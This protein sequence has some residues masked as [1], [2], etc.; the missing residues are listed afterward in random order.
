MLK[1]TSSAFKLLYT[2]LIILN[3]MLIE[4]SNTCSHYALNAHTQ[5]AHSHTLLN[6]TLQLFA[7]LISLNLFRFAFNSANPYWASH[8]IAA[9]HMVLK[10]S[11][12]H[13]LFTVSGTH[14]N[15]TI[16][17]LAL[18]P[19]AITCHPVACLKRYAVRYTPPGFAPTT[20]SHN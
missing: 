8:T 3:T 13:L 1:K 18:T 4:S 5:N 11:Q 14:T 6:I 10:E 20:P 17:K 16:C 7:I 15:S 12:E 9:Q 2:V 19:T